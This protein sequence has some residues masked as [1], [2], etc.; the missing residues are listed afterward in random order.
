MCSN[1][2][3]QPAVFKLIAALTLVAGHSSPPSL[4]PSRCVRVQENLTTRTATQAILKHIVLCPDV[5]HAMS[6]CRC[7]PG[8]PSAAACTGALWG[9]WHPTSQARPGA[10]ICGICNGAT[11]VHRQVSYMSY[12]AEGR[13]RG[14]AGKGGRGLLSAQQVAS[15]MRACVDVLHRLHQCNVQFTR[16]VQASSNVFR[17]IVWGCRERG[18]CIVV[19]AST[20]PLAQSLG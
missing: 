17:P 1:Q 11:E 14:G 16:V 12:G 2:V 3:I 9:A 7:C 8:P 6:L 4:H 5:L 20:V 13:Q 15:E 10:E 19:F 18:G